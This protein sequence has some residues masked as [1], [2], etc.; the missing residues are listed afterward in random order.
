ML[1]NNYPINL[2]YAFNVAKSLIYL[3]TSKCIIFLLDVQ[4][5]KC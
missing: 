4:K 1:Q 3:W 2:L 5:A